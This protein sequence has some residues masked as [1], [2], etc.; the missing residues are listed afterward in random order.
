MD[1]S[2]ESI[3]EI[4]QQ[5]TQAFQAAVRAHQQAGGQ[6]LTIADVETG[7][8]QLL[9]QV[10]MQSLSQFLSTGQGTPVAEL[11]CP[12]GGRVRYQRQRAAS[13]TSVFGRLRYERAYYAGCACGQGQ[14][15]VDAQY[16]LQPGAVTSG[17]A[18]LLSL[19]GI[20]FGFDESRGWLQ[21]FL[22][23]DVSENTIRSETQT[24]GAL[25]AEREQVLCDQSQDEAYLQA[26]LRET[27]PVPARLFGSL[28]AAKVRIE[29]RAKGGNKP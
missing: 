11:A 12:C 9:R 24:F 8:R 3:A 16:G 20:E 6:A 2:T 18:A 1:Y 21:P 17:L 22:L 14:A 7:L 4:G 28:D 5:V 10:G 26:R 27:Q 25:Q 19:A 13:I 23:F 29:P 15:P